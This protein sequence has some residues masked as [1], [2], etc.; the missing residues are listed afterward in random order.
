MAR[1]PTDGWRW[2]AH[3]ETHRPRPQPDTTTAFPSSHTLPT[4]KTDGF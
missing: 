3:A 1:F 4:W 2:Q